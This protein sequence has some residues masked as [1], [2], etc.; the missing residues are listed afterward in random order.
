MSGLSSVSA[1]S[2]LLN[3][4]DIKCFLFMGSLLGLLDIKSKMRLVS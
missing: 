3:V 4:L 1:M 2:S